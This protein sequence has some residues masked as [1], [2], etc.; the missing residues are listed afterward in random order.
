MNELQDAFGNLAVFLQKHEID[1][2]DVT[3]NLRCKT[4]EQAYHVCRAI[5]HDVSWQ[6][7]TRELIG[8]SRGGPGTGQLHGLKFSVSSL[9]KRSIT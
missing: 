1:P 4:D 3:V 2:E 6:D 9:D 7:M 8:E 5:R